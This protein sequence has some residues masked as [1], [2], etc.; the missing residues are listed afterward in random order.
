MTAEEYKAQ[1]P[2]QLNVMDSPTF[3]EQMTKINDDDNAKRPIFRP[4]Q[5]K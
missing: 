1:K 3:V 4:D 2:G 5:P